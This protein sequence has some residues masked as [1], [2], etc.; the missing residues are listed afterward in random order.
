MNAVTAFALCF[1]G[2]DDNII[3]KKKKLFNSFPSVLC[4]RG[5]CMFQSETTVDF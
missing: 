4:L 2:T 3:E 5:S 1:G